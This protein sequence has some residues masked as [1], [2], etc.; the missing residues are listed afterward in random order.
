MRKC[1]GVC[2]GSGLHARQV[3]SSLCSSVRST[4]GG[5]AGEGSACLIGGWAGFKNARQDSLGVAKTA[6]LVSAQVGRLQKGNG[7]KVCQ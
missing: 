2:D 1:S 4:Q 5:C 3:A 6:E 7:E